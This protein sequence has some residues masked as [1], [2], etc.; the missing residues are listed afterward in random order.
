MQVLRILLCHLLG[1]IQYRKIVITRQKLGTPF[2]AKSLFP[3][4][5]SLIEHI[6]MNYADVLVAS[7]LLMYLKMLIT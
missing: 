3:H 2:C 4:F 5:D 6:E 7:Q 1:L